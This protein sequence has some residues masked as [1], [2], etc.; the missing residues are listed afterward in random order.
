MF[1]FQPVEFLNAVQVVSCSSRPGPATAEMGR[2][3]ANRQQVAAAKD[4]GP[5]ALEMKRAVGVPFL[6]WNLGKIYNDIYIYDVYIYTQKVLMRNFACDLIE[7][8]YF[9]MAI[10]TT[11]RPRKPR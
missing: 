7:I 11:H 5:W 6:D 3:H 4:P 9:A 2:G 8:R 1:D 10:W